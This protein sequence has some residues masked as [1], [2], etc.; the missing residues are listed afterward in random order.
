MNRR[1]IHALAIV[2]TLSASLLYAAQAAHADTAQA[3]GGQALETAATQPRQTDSRLSIIKQLSGE[4]VLVVSY[5]WQKHARP[6]VEFRVLRE[7]EID[8]PL[9]RPLYFLRDVMK[10]KVTEAV[11]RCEDGAEDLPQTA[12]FSQDRTDFE[13]FGR[14]NLLGRP[15]VCIASRTR[16]IDPPPETRA[17]FCSLDA[18][19]V[20]E[21][22]LYLELPDEYFAE[23]CQLRV[24]FL[25]DKSI[26]WKQTILWPGT[27]KAAAEPQPSAAG[28]APAEEPP[29]ATE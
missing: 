12:T 6:S 19:A 28:K 4:P 20:D 14:R 25:R 22:T 10:G 15:A 3:S 18:W 13:I 11:Y 17:F 27:G 7:G 1:R 23:P 16:S 21:R 9:V 26:V 2:T 5:P 29:P 24:W 8:D